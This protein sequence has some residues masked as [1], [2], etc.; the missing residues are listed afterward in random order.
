[1]DMGHEILPSAKRPILNTVIGR[2]IILFQNTMPIDRRVNDSGARMRAASQQNPVKEGPL[3]AA[4]R[5]GAV[6]VKRPVTSDH[7]PKS[8][9]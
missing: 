6:R 1:M 2:H 9:A 3:F 7:T 4:T 5:F 8:L